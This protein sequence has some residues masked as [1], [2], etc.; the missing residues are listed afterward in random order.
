MGLNG[1]EQGI[2]IQN[3]DQGS[4]AEQA[5]LRGS[6]KSVTIGGKPQHV[7]GDIIVAL[8]GQAVSQVQD[9]Q[10][11]LQQSQPGEQALVTI[12]RGGRLLQAFVTLGDLPATSTT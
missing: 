8:D 7:G 6:H 10:A 5:G 2:L 3:V 11:F 4:P 1:T 12:L 9:L